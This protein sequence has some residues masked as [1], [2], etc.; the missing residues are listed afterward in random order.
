ME[1]SIIPLF[2]KP[3]LSAAGDAAGPPYEGDV[4]F[5]IEGGLPGVQFEIAVPFIRSESLDA[6]LAQAWKHLA[7]F[8]DQMAAIA[9]EKSA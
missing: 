4:M 3:H 2:I 1:I 5:T 8:A 9:R 6:G 7:D